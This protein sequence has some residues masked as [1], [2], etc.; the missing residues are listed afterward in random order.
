[1]EKNDLFQIGEVSRLFHI[2]VGTL[3][4]YEKI[5]LLQPEYTDPDTGYRYYS[6]RQFECLNTIRYLRALDMPLENIAQFLGNRDIDHMCRLLQRQ[7]EE[8]ARRQQELA[9]IQ[10]K[11]EN[12]LSQL[13]D[14]VS[15]RLDSIT[16]EKR[17][18]RR[19]ASVKEKVLPRCYL[20]L[21]YSIRE[22]EQLEEN[23]VTFLGKVGLGIPAESLKERKFQPY[24]MVFII[25]D[26]E[27]C[28]KGDTIRIP[29]ETCAVIRFQGGHEQAPY[30]Y[31]RLMDYI[32][33]NQYKAVGFSKEITMIDYG[34]TND[35]SKFVTEIQIPVQK[36]AVF[37]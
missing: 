5:G 21:E 10:K 4:H 18:A 25:L 34:L 16:L 7:K 13:K 24:E 3:R 14:A 27:D 20:D 31:H 30:Y 12:R 9:V 17:P 32:E 29:E 22:L 36:E 11:I 37:Q 28:F 6:A 8:A 1:M 15:S 19:I 23:T 33:E 26:E 35:I 2:S